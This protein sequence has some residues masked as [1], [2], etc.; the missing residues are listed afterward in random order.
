MVLTRTSHC[1]H[2][3]D[4]ATWEGDGQNLERQPMYDEMDLV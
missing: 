2:C 1:E 3:H 4:L